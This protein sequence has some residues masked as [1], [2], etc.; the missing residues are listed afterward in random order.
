MLDNKSLYLNRKSRSRDRDE[1]NLTQEKASKYKDIF[2]IKSFFSE[3]IRKSSLY[4]VFAISMAGLSVYVLSSPNILTSFPFITPTARNISNLVGVSEE[5]ETSLATF[6]ALSNDHTDNIIVS[7]GEL[8]RSLY[9]GLPAEALQTLTGR[10][11]SLLQRNRTLRNNL[12]QIDKGAETLFSG[13]RAR[14]EEI[15]A[16][17]VRTEMTSEINR[18]RE[19]FDK[20]IATLEEALSELESSIQ[21]YEDTLSQLN[22]STGLGDE[23]AYAIYISDEIERVKVTTYNIENSLTENQDVIASLFDT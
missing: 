18:N 19:A 2:H 15:S 4:A 5:L 10:A 11:D 13:L 8:E 14:A 16:P 17:D 7:Y 1:K 12:D 21:A 3:P 9:N 23:E 20:N 22:V 6:K